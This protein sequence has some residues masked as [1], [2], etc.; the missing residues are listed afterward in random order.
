MS[1]ACLQDLPDILASSVPGIR[2]AAL[3]LA[4][5][6]LKAGPGSPP[7]T[8]SSY[9]LEAHPVRCSILLHVAGQCSGLCADE[10][11]SIMVGL[12]NFLPGTVKSEAVAL[13]S[14]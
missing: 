10:L 1:C 7:Q 2:K 12:S 14:L 11:T 9:G 8:C 6:T 4:V 3:E 13:R 5:A